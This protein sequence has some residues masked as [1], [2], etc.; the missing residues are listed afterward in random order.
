M[1]DEAKL[2]YWFEELDKESNDL[3]GKKGANLGEMTKLGL[4]VVPG[5]VVSIESYRRF[6][7]ETGVGEQI[8]KYIVSLGKIDNIDKCEEVSKTIRAMI[9]KQQ[10]LG[11]LEE[12]IGSYYDTLCQNTGIADVAVSTRSGGPVSRPGMFDTFINVKGKEQV[13]QHVKKVWSSTFTG[14]AIWYRLVHDIPVDGDVLGVV[15]MKLVDARSA[16]I[17]FTVDPVTGDRTKIII[18]AS[19]G[20][21]E[22]V[23]SG[24][25]DVD[26]FVINKETIEIAERAI[27]I[28]KFCIASG[29]EGVEERDIP[30]AKQSVSCLSDEEIK[31]I[32]KLGKSLEE[33]LGQ[34]QDIEWALDPDLSFPNNLFVFQTRPAK[35][36]TE[37]AT[38][39]LDRL[40]DIMAK[41]ASRGGS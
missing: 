33:R 30:P 5:Y 6:M 7:A 2:V 13:L 21:G 32:A 1:M 3:V 27:G 41:R 17:T 23:V 18:D 29:K 12:K 16:G 4:P 11:Y 19:W 36:A 15:V 14:R 22:G 38:T 28:K 25:V 40:A 24:K 35:F 31:E 26:R 8:S 39:V 34:P 10:M 37:K 9:E 20:L